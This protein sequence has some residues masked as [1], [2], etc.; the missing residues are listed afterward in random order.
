[1][2]LFLSITATFQEQFFPPVRF[3]VAQAAEAGLRPLVLLP[4]KRWDG[5]CALSY[6]GLTFFNLLEV[7]TPKLPKT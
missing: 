6:L 7:R 1:M 5:R 3:S 2:E 4:P